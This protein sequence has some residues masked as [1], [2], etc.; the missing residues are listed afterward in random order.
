MIHLSRGVY[1]SHLMDSKVKIVY[2]GNNLCDLYINDEYKGLA[3]F[4]YTKKALNSLE[5]KEAQ[6]D[7]KPV[8]KNYA[9]KELKTEIDMSV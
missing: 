8:M 1:L 3:P 9:F 4:D 5:N 7:A 6:Q 2:K